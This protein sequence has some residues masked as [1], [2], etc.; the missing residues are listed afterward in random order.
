MSGRYYIKTFGCQMNEYDSARMADVLRVRRGPDAHRRPGR[1][2]RAAAEHLLGAREGAGEGVLAA[3]RVARAEAAAARTSSSASAAASPARKARRSRRARPSST[4]CSVRRRCTGCRDARRAATPRARRRRRELPGDREVRPPAG[5]ARR[6][7]RAPS[8]RSW[9][10]AAS[11]AASASCPTR[12]ATKSAGPFDA[13]AGRGAR[14][15]RQGVREVTL[16]GQNVNA[17]A[18]DMARRRARRPGDADPPRRRAST[19]SS[20]SASPPRT[21]WSSPTA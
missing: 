16:L 15:R 10:A 11:T 4:W 13:G 3:G 19:A 8:S 20:A 1:R 21:R 14:A 12:A 5:A 17:Y 9:K 6:G 2:R 18:G 7:R